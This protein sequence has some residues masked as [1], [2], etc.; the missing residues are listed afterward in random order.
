[1]IRL[2]PLEKKGYVY[3]DWAMTVGWVLT[4]SSLSCIPIYAIYHVYN[5]PGESLVVKFVSS[6]KPTVMTSTKIVLENSSN[7][8]ETRKLNENNS[9]YTQRISL[10]DVDDGQVSKQLDS[11]S[12]NIGELV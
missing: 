1:M 5:K 4:F 8:D 11:S 2:P 9:C 12:N 10:A 3:P 6:F 7:Q